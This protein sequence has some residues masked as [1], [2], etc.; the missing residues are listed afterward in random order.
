MSVKNSQKLSDCH[1]ANRFIFF[2][3]QQILVVAYHIFR[4]ARQSDFNDMIIIW[5]AAD[6]DRAVWLNAFA[7]LDK[8]AD[9]ILNGFRINV[10]FALDS[11]I[12]QCFSQFIQQGLRIKQ[13]KFAIP[14]AQDNWRDSPE[15]CD[16]GTN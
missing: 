9:E 1:K 4:I 10:I 6:V 12:L 15:W 8:H 7:V 3:H 11:R 5:V 2:E 13:S 16:G 14:Q